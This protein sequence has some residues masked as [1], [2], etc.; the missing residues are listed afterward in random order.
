MPMS[1]VI[2]QHYVPQSYLKNFSSDKSQISVFEKPT[3]RSFTTNVRNIAS[4][5]AFYDF[6]QSA[7]Q[8]E[9]IQII[10]QLF[11]G[12]ETRQDRLLRH[13]QRKINGIFQ[14]RL[15]PNQA[16]R[17]YS[18]KALTAE[19]RQDL[20]CIVSIQFLRTKEFRKFIIEMRQKAEPL[21]NHIL[22]ESILD[23]IKHFEVLTSAN[24]DEELTSGLK[25]LIFD[26]CTSII[27][28]LYNERLSVIHAKFILDHYE[29]A[30][31]ILNNHIWIIGVNDTGQPLFTSDH[32]VVRHP[33]LSSGGIASE[34][35]EIA[36]PINNKAILIMREK[37]HFQRFANQ[38]NKLFPLTL[39]DVEHYNRLQIYNSNRFVF[40][41]DECFDL[42][43]LV[44]EQQPEFCSEDRSR[45]QIKTIKS[46]P[47]EKDEQS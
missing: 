7:T 10:E 17:T 24:I 1:Q 35:I 16:G 42:V 22:E 8:P 6:P 40:C 26:K 29:Q 31:Q 5:R 15:T 34:G 33:Y 46:Q 18:I 3:K 45:I 41:G 13:L 44:C 9:N 19:Q 38:D 47:D 20:A 28:S 36:F 21:T 11:S 4:E 39:E 30:A 27:S 43:K 23:I 12:L 37:R 32:P 2:N 14:L 25:S